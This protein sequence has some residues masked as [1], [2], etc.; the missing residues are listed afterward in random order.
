[1]FMKKIGCGVGDWIGAEFISAYNRTGATVPRGGCAMLDILGTQAETTSIVPGDPASVFANLTPVTQT[2]FEN[3]FPILVACAD[4]ADNALG[5]WF[6]AGV[7]EVAVV[8]DD[9]STTDADRGNRA[10]MLV[11]ES[12]VG[13]CEY[14]TG[15]TGTRNVGI[16]LEDGAAS[17]ATAART[18]D[19]SHHLRY[20]IYMGGIP[21][22]GS[23]D[24]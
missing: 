2:E 15:G 10:S 7:I 13:L 6:I 14:V 11:S 22:F 20:V 5:L 1:M 24:T 16:F 18:Y 12:A 23:T 9:V 8:D 3:G 17:S 21:C 4:I 19:A